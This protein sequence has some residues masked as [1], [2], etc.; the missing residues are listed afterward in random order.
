MVIKNEQE[1][2]QRAFQKKSI[3]IWATLLLTALMTANA[4]INAAKAPPIQE[5]KP[6][7]QEFPDPK[8]YAYQ[9]ALKEYGW[10]KIQQKCLGILWGK[11]AAWDYTAKSLTDD[12]GIPQRHMRYNTI[13]QINDFMESPLIQ[14]DWGLNYI[15]VRYG[16]PCQAWDFWEKNRWY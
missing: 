6:E 3:R 1:T 4:P 8:K 2:P 11:E 15:K 12:Y 10:G 5:I 7:A 14:I 9:T 13:E 16:S